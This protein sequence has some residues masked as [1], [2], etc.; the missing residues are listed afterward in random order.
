MC[1]ASSKVTFLSV[2]AETALRVPGRGDD[3]RRGRWRS[4]EA[5]V[6]AT[7][8]APPFARRSSGLT[9]ASL[10]LFPCFSGGCGH[11]ARAGAL[12]PRL[13]PETTTSERNVHM[14]KRRVIGGLAALLLVPALAMAQKV[15]YDFSKSANF[16][17]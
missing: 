3:E 16:A 12:H 15:S 10:S 1:G 9:G 7:L 6:H 2:R 11:F 5:Y 4:S 17:S 13:C 14:Q 8:P